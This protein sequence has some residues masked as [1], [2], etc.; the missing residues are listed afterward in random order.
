MIS[1]NSSARTG[2][3]SQLFLLLLASS[4]ICV[5]LLAC[6]SPEQKRAQ[7]QKT[8]EKLSTSVAKHLFDR[9]P[10]TVRESINRLHR[11]ELSEAAFEKLQAGGYLPRTE[12]GILKITTEA[13][14]SHQTNVVQVKTVK[15]SGDIDNDLVPMQVDG[16]V[17]TKTQGKADISKPFQ[18]TV[19]CLWNAKTS[20]YPQ[21]T[22]VTVG[23]IPKPAAVA[24]VSSKK[25][26]RRR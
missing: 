20:D 5:L 21:V 6:S 16:I 11:E 12:L 18:I 24:K 23:N 10:D 15:A 8:L 19:S 9:N 14:E 13:E 3:G 17:T 7:R 2:F 1:L 26:K 25:K 4:L 22:D